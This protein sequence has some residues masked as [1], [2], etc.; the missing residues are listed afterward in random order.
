VPYFRDVTRQRTEFEGPINHIRIRTAGKHDDVRLLFLHN[1]ITGSRQS[2]Y[3]EGTG[4]TAADIGASRYAA[5][6]A[7]HVHLAQTIH[8]NIH[9]V[10]SPICEDFGELNYRHRIMAVTIPEGGKK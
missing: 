8:G 7:G 4:L 10:G 5:V 3:T 1:T 6:F 2:L 9:V